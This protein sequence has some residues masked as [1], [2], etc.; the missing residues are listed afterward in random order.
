MARQVVTL[1]LN[2]LVGS[3]PSAPIE[4]IYYKNR[5]S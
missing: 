4:A 5:D 3:N 2:R 1:V